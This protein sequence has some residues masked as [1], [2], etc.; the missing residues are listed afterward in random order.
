MSGAP[1]EPVRRAEG[2][3][4]HSETRAAVRA[5]K[6]ARRAATGHTGAC[7]G[8]TDGENGMEGAAGDGRPRRL[9]QMDQAPVE[10]IYWHG[11]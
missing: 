1:S 9:I 6:Q 10:Y 4:P 3:A 7:T 8:H 11:V 5:G 2:A